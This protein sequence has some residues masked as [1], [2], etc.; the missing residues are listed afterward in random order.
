MKLTYED[1]SQPVTIKDTTNQSVKTG[2]YLSWTEDELLNEIRRR[3]LAHG[4]NYI[5]V[6]DGEL[7][8]SCLVEML[9]GNDAFR[10]SLEAVARRFTK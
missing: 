5:S 6:P 1:L 9:V 8:K 10:Q 4:V 3:R 7:R 2:D